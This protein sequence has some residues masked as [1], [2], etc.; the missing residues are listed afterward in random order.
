MN[1]VSDTTRSDATYDNV[2]YL[3]VCLSVSLSVCPFVRSFVWYQLVNA[4]IEN[5]FNA[6]WRKW[7]PG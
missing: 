7:S 4:V 5:D 3:S 6:T 1:S 2:L